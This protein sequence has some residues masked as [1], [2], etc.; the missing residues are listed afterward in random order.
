MTPTLAAAVLLLAAACL[1]LV[2][3]QDTRTQTTL[4]PPTAPTLNPNSTGQANWTYA[5]LAPTAPPSGQSDGL[6]LEPWVIVI[7]VFVGVVM[8]GLLIYAAK[9]GKAK[10]DGARQH[11]KRTAKQDEE[12]KKRMEKLD[13]L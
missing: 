3:C 11:D 9:R 6:G 8:C 10:R 5:P 7:L 4:A 12:F 2:S 1:P 13:K